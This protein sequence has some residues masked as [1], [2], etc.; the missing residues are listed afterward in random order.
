MEHKTLIIF[1]WDDTLF[2]TSWLVQNN[3]NISDELA[4]NKYII[5]FTRLDT[6][7]NQLLIIAMK[8]GKVIIVTNAVNKWIETSLNMLPNTKKLIQSNINVISAR[9]IYQEKYPD[10]MG[11][12]KR[13]VFQN[14]VTDHFKTYPLQNII[15]I[16]DAEHEFNALVDLYNAHSVVKKRLLKTVRFMKDPTFES[17]LDQLNVLKNS[18]IQ[19]IRSKKH[20][21]LVFQTSIYTHFD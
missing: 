13:L 6:L 7:L 20:M 21:D 16:G 9:E 2:P 11:Q 17:L 5:L 8:H 15:S 3:I 18:L 14:Y 12:W 10:Q 1:D 4:R 19:I